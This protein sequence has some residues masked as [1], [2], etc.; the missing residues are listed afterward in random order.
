[1]HIS[2]PDPSLQQEEALVGG[3]ARKIER[4]CVV[5]STSCEPLSWGIRVLMTKNDKPREHIHPVNMRFRWLKH[6]LRQ[7]PGNKHST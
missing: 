4:R 7:R 6:N 2:V 1:M 3:E 5:K